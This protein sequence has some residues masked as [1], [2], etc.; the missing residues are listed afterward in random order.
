MRLLQPMVLPLL[1]VACGGDKDPDDTDSDTANT[2][3]DTDTT[4]VDTD[5]GDPVQSDTVSISQ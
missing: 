3:T 5:D 4:A 2:T 1:L